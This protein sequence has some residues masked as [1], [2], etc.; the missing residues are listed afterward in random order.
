[1]WFACRILDD[2]THDVDNTQTR[3]DNVMKKLA[4]VSHMTSGKEPSEQSCQDLSVE[5]RTFRKE[6]N[7]M[8]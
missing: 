1:M 2:F 7:E 5:I 3:L 8:S 4:K 6:N